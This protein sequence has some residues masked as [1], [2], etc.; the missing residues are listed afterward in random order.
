[1]F[2]F[3]LKKIA[4]EGRVLTN[5]LRA[6]AGTRAQCVH[7]RFGPRFKIKTVVPDGRKAT[8][9]FIFEIPVLARRHH[10]IDSAPWCDHVPLLK[11]T[12]HEH[13]YVSNRGQLDCSFNNSSRWQQGIIKALHY[14]PFVSRISIARVNKAERV[15]ISCRQHRADF[16]ITNIITNIAP[17]SLSA[18]IAS[19]LPW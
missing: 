3:Q 11:M 17:T 13:H 18:Q 10:Y 8:L 14:W 6:R 9:F 4:S 15:P 12:P 16:I 7:M 5:W 2:K 19:R 1:M